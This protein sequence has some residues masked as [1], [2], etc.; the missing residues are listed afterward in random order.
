MGTPVFIS[1]N[2]DKR[3][4]S[5]LDYFGIEYNKIVEVDV[6]KIKSTFIDFLKRKFGK[7]IVQSEAVMPNVS[8]EH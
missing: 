2:V 7:S 1:P 3:R 8:K 4:F 5:I 6:G